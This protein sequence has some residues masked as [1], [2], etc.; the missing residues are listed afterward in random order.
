M[1]AGN[2]TDWPRCPGI[3]GQA[4]RCITRTRDGQRCSRCQVQL[5]VRGHTFVEPDLEELTAAGQLPGDA[6]WRRCRQCGAC[7]WEHSLWGDAVQEGPAPAPSDP[8]SDPHAYVGAGAR[9]TAQ[10]AAE[11]VLVR[12]GTQ[13][14]RVLAALERTGDRGATDDELGGLTAL[15]LN[16]VRPRR[17]ELVEA[18]YVMDS[19]DTRPSAQGNAAVVWLPT[20]E[21]LAALEGAGQQEART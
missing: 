16:S 11:G 7:R 5:D 21:G 1:S 4:P 14:H 19:G 18:G 15:A 9:P 8:L 20:L 10:A 3:P 2:A 6:A 13:R 17:L 12:S